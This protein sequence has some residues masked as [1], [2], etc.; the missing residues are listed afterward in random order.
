[1]DL[2]NPLGFRRRAWISWRQLNHFH[3]FNPSRAKNEFRR[4]LKKAGW[5]V[6]MW[7][8][9]KTNTSFLQAY[10]NLLQDAPIDRERAPHARVDE[11][12]LGDFFGKYREEKMSNSQ[13][14][15]Y[16]G[17]V[18]RFLSASYAPLPGEP[19]HEELISRLREIFDRYEVNGHV[20]FEYEVELY[21]GQLL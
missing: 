11:A 10:E 16:E 14:L 13:E 8:T 18:G 17:L 19:H 7:N 5:V 6:L 21:A 20:R 2:P 4:I 1:M 15:D 12:T 9:R 3:W